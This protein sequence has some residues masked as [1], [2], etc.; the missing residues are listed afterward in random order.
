MLI[1]ISG[2]VC[3]MYYGYGP[4]MRSHWTSWSWGTKRVKFKA[5][6]LAILKY[7]RVYNIS[8]CILARHLHRNSEQPTRDLLLYI[9]WSWG[10][11][12]YNLH[13]IFHYFYSFFS[14]HGIDAKK[15][16]LIYRFIFCQAWEYFCEMFI[17]MCVFEVAGHIVYKSI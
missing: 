9:S 4:A 15:S 8:P 10:N 17:R 14:G 3:I 11:K 5:D 1:Y 7:I 13:F 12:N 6:I 2:I 16:I